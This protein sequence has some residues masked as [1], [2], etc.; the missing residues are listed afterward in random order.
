MWPIY[1]ACERRGP[2]GVLQHRRNTERALADWALLQEFHDAARRIHCGG[3]VGCGWW[4]PRRPSVTAL[5][6][7]RSMRQFDRRA[8]VAA[9]KSIVSRT[10][11]ANRSPSR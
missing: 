3:L 10:I 11:A 7:S 6:G 4:W 8:I 1:R 2:P 9:R 5:P